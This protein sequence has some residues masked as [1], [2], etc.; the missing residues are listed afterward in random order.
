MLRRLTFLLATLLGMAQAAPPLQPLIDATP[1]GG[2]LRP[3]PGIYAGPAVIAK[4][5]TL[6]GGGK[7]TLAGNGRG[8]VLTL[9]TSG[10]TLRGLRLTGSGDSHDGI[11]AGLLVAGDDNLVEHNAIDDVLFGIHL[12]Q[13]NR[14][15]IRANRVTG[16]AAPRGARGDGLRLWNSR[17]NRIEGNAFRTVRD[18]TFANSPDNLILRNTLADGRYGMQF[19]FSPRARVEG[20]RLADTDTGIAVLYSPD[21][22]LRGNTIAHALD[23][24]GAGLSLK[25]SGGALV[26]DNE[27]LHCA[28]GLSANAPLN[29]ETALTVRGN[30]F[31]HNIVGMYFYG[32]QGGHKIVDNRFE[33]N[34]TQVAVSAAGVGAANDWTGNLWSDYQGFDRDGDGIGDTPHEVWLYSDRIWMETPRAKFFANSPAL[35]LLDFLEKLAPFAAPSLI[36]RDPAPR[37]AK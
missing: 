32:E 21:L 1:A 13:G 20:N 24:G 27:I 7:A 18:L 33:N 19:V 35:E 6:D 4:P 25:D 14:N 3:A 23:G 17:H 15:R 30:R 9:A 29:A 37:M 28:A 26:E 36:L 12:R 5:I 34:L 16:R 11:D 31:A 22:V 10:A 8:T 2:T